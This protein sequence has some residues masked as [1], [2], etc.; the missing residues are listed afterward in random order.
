VS[1]AVSFVIPGD[2]IGKPRQ[3]RRDRWAQRP[4]VLKYRSW[5][6]VARLV[7]PRDLPAIPLD[8]EVRVFL[9][10][11]RSYSQA[12]RVAHEGMPHRAKPDIDNLLKSVMDAL[13]PEDSHIA[14][15]TA[16]KFW[17]DGNGP[18]VEVSVYGIEAQAAA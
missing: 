11:P 17:D 5:A 13:W 2:P 4:S 6:D 10:I 14:R 18:R 12:Q 1:K 9:P 7:A 8:L 15:V 3:T 16:S